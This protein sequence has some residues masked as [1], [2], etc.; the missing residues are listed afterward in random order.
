MFPIGLN[1]Y[2]FLGLNAVRALS[3]LTLILVFAS[4][5]VVMVE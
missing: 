3:I 4:S 1:A 2:T 5:I